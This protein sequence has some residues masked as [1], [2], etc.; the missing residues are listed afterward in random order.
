MIHNWD[1]DCKKAI[2]IMK[3]AYKS[4]DKGKAEKSLQYYGRLDLSLIKPDLRVSL[5]KQRAKIRIL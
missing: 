1:S 2:N 5:E 4:K 3:D